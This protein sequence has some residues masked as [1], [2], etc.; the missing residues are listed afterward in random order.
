M[1]EFAYFFSASLADGTK[2]YIAELTDDE[3]L[4][5]GFDPAEAV[6]YFLYRAM[7]KQPDTIQ[8]L[9]RVPTHGAAFELSRMLSLT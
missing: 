8:V 4:A 5:A 1:D 9:A 3:A 6:G 2:L 7:P